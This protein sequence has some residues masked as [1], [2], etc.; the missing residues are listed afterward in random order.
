MIADLNIKRNS[1]T[2]LN[3][4][5]YQQIN[6]KLTHAQLSIFYKPR[7]SKQT[8]QLSKGPNNGARSDCL[9]CPSANDFIN[10]RT[11]ANTSLGKSC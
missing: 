1:E 3:C 2:Y 7:K 4:L 11:R 9:R 8:A 6:N 5:F 10:Y